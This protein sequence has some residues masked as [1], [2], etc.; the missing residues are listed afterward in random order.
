MNYLKNNFWQY[1]SVFALL[2]MVSGCNP[3]STSGAPID[4]HDIPVPSGSTIYTGPYES[5]VDMMYI[6]T[7]RAF[8]VS[9]QNCEANTLYYLLERTGYGLDEYLSFYPTAFATT[10]WQADKAID[11]PGV[12]RWTRTS[13][14]GSQALTIGVIPFTRGDTVEYLLMLVLVTGELPCHNL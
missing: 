7:R 3:T 1:I 12:R 14:A 13:T 4:I 2:V 11:L 5:T 9:N 6:T 10:D 8:G